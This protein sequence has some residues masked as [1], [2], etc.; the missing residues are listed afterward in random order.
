MFN[1]LHVEV[2]EA[3]TAIRVRLVDWHDS[4]K[5]VEVVASTLQ[6]LRSM[7]EDTTK[8]Y[9]YDVRNGR[10]RGTERVKLVGDSEFTVLK[11]Q[12]ADARPVTVYF[13]AQRDGDEDP[14]S[15]PPGEAPSVLPLSDTP[16]S[17]SSR[18]TTVQNLFRD[19][20][21]SRYLLNR[22]DVKCLLCGKSED[23]LRFEACH[24]IPYN[25]SKPVFREYGLINGKIDGLN[26]VFFCHECHQYYD[27][28][29]WNWTIEDSAEHLNATVVVSEGLRRR[30]PR[31]NSLHTT[32]VQLGKGPNYPSER[33][34][35]AG[36]K[37]NFSDPHASRTKRR[38]DKGPRCVKCGK[39]YKR[40]FD[41]H[42]CIQPR[43]E[44]LFHTPHAEHAA[45]SGRGGRGRTA[46]GRGGRSNAGGRRA[47]PAMAAIQGASPPS[48]LTAP[49]GANMVSVAGPTRS[50]PAKS[51][52]S[53]KGGTP[54]GSQ[55][56]KN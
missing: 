11:Q 18:S 38:K 16:T 55:S 8:L 32:V 24:I 56:R 36:Y 29:H 45:R 23:G 37:L 5:S 15:P 44:P 20:V 35:Q 53:K 30:Y 43:R 10:L 6:Q 25:C 12:P 51:S 40:D 41:M 52:K 4:S 31:W 46:T 26:G 48:L 2:M 27:N 1:K 28:G 22:E 54:T 19:N 50:A 33:V 21:E 13:Y 42:G 49:V 39:H 7:V 3:V 47:P 9:F 17:S 14:D 34:W